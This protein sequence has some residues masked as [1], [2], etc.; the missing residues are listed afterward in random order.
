M[1][2]TFECFVCVCG[3]T[4]ICHGGLRFEHKGV[5]VIVKLSVGFQPIDWDIYLFYLVELSLYWS[6]LFSMLFLND[7]KK[8]VLCWQCDFTAL[9][10]AYTIRTF[11]S[12]DVFVLH[13]AL[14]IF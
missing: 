3:M 14:S 1:Y 13:T 12:A 8:K 7:Y 4:V 9:N 10:A 2:S 5:L 6:L 11:V